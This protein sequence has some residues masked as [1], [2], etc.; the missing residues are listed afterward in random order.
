MRYCPSCDEE[1]RDDVAACADD[2]TP[3]LDREAWEAERTRQGRRPEPLT[4]LEAIARFDSRFEAEEIA[5]ELAK[6]GVEVS[7]VST[8]PGISGPLTSAL[9]AE[10][11]LVVP[12]A[13]AERAAALVDEWRAELEASATDAEKAAEA[14]E[15]ADELEG[16]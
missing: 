5:A 11:S 7:L 4:H 14:A 16:F 9:P 1:Y 8:K 12:A 2:G 13:Q 6:E 15:A 3:L 10:W